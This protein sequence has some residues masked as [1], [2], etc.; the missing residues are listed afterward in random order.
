MAV[1][2]VAR[3]P[4][5][6]GASLSSEVQY[7][8]QRRT[9]V[10]PPSNAITQFAQEKRRSV[11]AMNVNE[12]NRR[13]SSHLAKL[14][15]PL[16]GADKEPLQ[17]KIAEAVAVHRKKYPDYAHNPR[18]AHQRK[19]QERIAKQ[20]TSKLNIDSSWDK[21][22]QPLTST[23]AAQCRGGPKFQQQ[24]PPLSRTSRSKRRA[25][26]S[27]RHAD[28]QQPTCVCMPTTAVPATTKDL[29]EQVVPVKVVA[30]RA[31][32]ELLKRQP[33][34]FHNYAEL[35]LIKIFGTMKEPER[36]VKRAAELCSIESVPAL[37]P[38]QTIRLIGESDDQDVVIAVIK[39]M[40]RLDVISS[41][42]R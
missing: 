1:P 8:Y 13:V 35:T 23:V 21:E 7:C 22:Q 19:E 3:H 28:H 26:I 16:R 6:A 33:Q 25:T 31:L 14:W 41:Y 37:H 18:E 9:R 36:E 27:S 32:T 17:P 15:R 34:H 4:G 11:A 42:Q 12:H 39:A 20:V 2:D 10:H 30:F 24:L 29:E 5:M 40:S 38:E